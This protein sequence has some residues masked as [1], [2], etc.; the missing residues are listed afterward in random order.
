[1][2]TK[3]DHL[4]LKGTNARR[5]SYLPIP[6]RYRQS[7][8]VKVLELSGLLF[9]AG[10]L[11]AGCSI[12]R[13]YPPTVIAPAPPPP[14]TLPADQFLLAPDHSP[15]PT[16]VATQP[17]GPSPSPTKESPTVMPRLQTVYEQRD[18]SARGSYA[19]AM[20]MDPLNAGELRLGFTLPAPP[21]YTDLSQ[22]GYP[23]IIFV[24]Y[25]DDQSYQI[26]SYIYWGSADGFSTGRRTEL[27]T[28]GA[29][30][31]AVADLNNDGL[32]DIIFANL[33]DDAK[34][35][36]VN[37]YVYWGQPDGYSIDHRSELPGLGSGLVS[38]ADLNAD[39]WLEIVFS[40][41]Y[42]DDHTHEIDSY[43]YW[44]GPDGFSTDNRTDLPTRGVYANT[45]ADVNGDGWLDLVFSNHRL[46][47]DQSY[48]IGS[49]IYWGAPDGF[50]PD[51]RTEIATR[52]A[53][54]NAV[55]DLSGAN[56]DG[57]PDLLFSNFRDNQSRATESWIYWGSPAGFDPGNRL[58]LPT[59]G[60]TTNSVAD[61]NQD[62][63]RDLVFSQFRDESSYEIGSLIYWG[64]A[65]G[66]TPDNRTT[67]PTIGGVGNSVA[68]LNRD[69]WLDIVFSNFMSGQGFRHDSW[70][71][72]GGP[73]G[74]SADQRTCL[75]TLGAYDNTAVGGVLPYGQKGLGT[76]YSQPGG[77][78]TV[79]HIYPERGELI[80]LAFGGTFHTWVTATWDCALPTGTNVSLDVAT[81]A[82]G[83]TWSA[84]VSVAGA[85]HD[86]TNQASL[87]V[88]AGR[89]IR[90]RVTLHGS[91]DHRSSP[92]LTRVALIGWEEE[93]GWLR[94][95]QVGRSYLCPGRGLSR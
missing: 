50:S 65:A 41:H 19:A 79:P 85:S 13:V 1:M 10:L 5:G 6:D 70:I 2:L 4:R 37:N 31:V 76:T 8:L 16:A 74:F 52:G 22:D 94:L 54:D 12:P 18:W 32:L 90:Y 87:S 69:G 89:F 62:G 44:G 24:N 15:T 17:A 47:N 21:P 67:L 55:V 25:Y 80:S 93:T 64:S 20:A 59:W 9:V 86:G 34:N 33:H 27:P 23:D 28:V 48:E 39:G 3:K 71:Y 42:V 82:D 35:Y 14:P 72:W 73:Q 61:L 43:V 56:G 29:R 77:E 84:W 88:G 45:P 40:N 58:A 36:Q 92:I 63:Y 11:L 81:S 95:P 78:W 7:T 49:Y 68:D 91:P 51:R 26:N 30:G 46:N 38:T 66:Y 57:Y 60:A 75:P 53:T 83:Q